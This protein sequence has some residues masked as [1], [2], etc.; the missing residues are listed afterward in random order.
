MTVPLIVLAVLSTVG[1]FVGVPYALSGG[2]IPNYFEHTLEPI[3]A[4]APENS[5]TREGTGEAGNHGRPAAPQSHNGASPLSLGEGAQ[6]EP[7]AERVPTSEEVNME[8]LFSAISV[9]IAITGIAIGFL[10]FKKR[11]L[12]EMP[13]LLE[14]KYYVDEIYD[15]GVIH[16][17]EKG[18]RVGLWQ[19]FD[20]G[21]IDGTIHALG[22]SVVQIGAVARYLQIGFVRSYAAIILFGALAVVGYVIFYFA[23]HLIR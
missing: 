8:R 3:I 12:L 9:L 7:A 1:G 11:P 13:R 22:R 15:A 23:A 19:L 21:V 4:H 2:S 17:I 10:V 5:G 14:N 20:V 6:N 16:P 18:S